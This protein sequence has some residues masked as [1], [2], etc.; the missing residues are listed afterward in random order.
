M[1]QSGS[2]TDI[3]TTAQQ[4]IVSG[5]LPPP[6]SIDPHD[7]RP[8]WSF[9]ELALMFDKRPDQLVALLHEIGP[10]YLESDRGIPSSWRML[11]EL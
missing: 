11:V 8:V 1:D 3:H 6:F 5:H 10:V 9:I 4:L 2:V 7:G